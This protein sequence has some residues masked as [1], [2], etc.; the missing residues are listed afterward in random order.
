M[1]KPSDALEFLLPKEYLE[2]SEMDRRHFLEYALKLTALISTSSLIKPQESRAEPVSKDVP[3]RFVNIRIFTGSC[4]LSSYLSPLAKTTNIQ[5]L[6]PTWKVPGLANS[7]RASGKIS[8][9]VDTDTANPES[10][11]HALTD[12]SGYQMPLL[13]SSTIP[14]GTSSTATMK[15]LIEKNC[16]MIYGLESS[17]AH[18]IAYEMLNNPEPGSFTIGGYIHHH[19]KKSPALFPALGNKK[20]PSAFKSPSGSSMKLV[21]TGSTDESNEIK[22]VLESLLPHQAKNDETPYENDE[23]VNISR[24]KWLNQLSGKMNVALDSIRDSNI[25]LKPGISVLYQ[26]LGEAKN[27]VESKAF[28]SMMVQ[29]SSALDKYKKLLRRSAELARNSIMGITDPDTRNKN[30][31]IVKNTLKQ[32]DNEK[33]AVLGSPNLIFGKPDDEL[34]E[35]DIITGKKVTPDK[36]SGYG[37]ANFWI[38]YELAHIFAFAEVAFNDQKP[39]TNVLNLGFNQSMVGL[40]L[41]EGKIPIPCKFDNHF[42]GVLPNLLWNS[43][44]YYSFNTLLYEFTN[45][46]KSKNQKTLNSWRDTVIALYTEFPRSPRKNGAGSD[47]GYLACNVTL[48]SGRLNDDLKIYGKTKVDSGDSTHPGAWGVRSDKMKVNSRYLNLSDVGV[49]IANLFV[50][51]SPHLG[52]STLTGRSTILFALD[53]SGNIQFKEKLLGKEISFLYSLEDQ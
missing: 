31:S 39:L 40:K 42:N 11:F 2:M 26:L 16:A 38:S 51:E 48:F 30:V 18:G 22:Q 7:F 15:S 8:E 50:T 28:E 34:Y 32:I 47:H 4:Q 35:V 10:I 20:G 14:Y 21:T 33:N 19:S 36:A 3:S 53:S 46:I 49:S 6:K 43:L 5:G 24:R 41:K 23:N 12:V 25:E 44:F 29:Y 27:N 17:P 52:L 9:N 45:T 1:K 13:W 37:N